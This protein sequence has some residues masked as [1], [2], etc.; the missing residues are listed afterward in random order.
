MLKPSIFSYVYITIS[1]KN[2]QQKYIHKKYYILIIHFNLF[3]SF[4][5]YIIPFNIDLLKCYN[6]NFLFVN[7]KRTFNLP[8][9]QG[10]YLKQGTS[11]TY[12]NESLPNITGVGGI[13]DN[14]GVSLNGAFE[15]AGLSNNFG[16]TGITGRTCT[17][18][19][20]NASRSSSAYQ[21]NAKVNP[22]NAEILY[23]I[24]Y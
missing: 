5:Y 21:N 6:K 20:F 3:N 13:V 10:R 12:G 24:K 4:C 16:L 1:Y 15:S 17:T 22:D 9:F 11:G 18:Q 2:Y 23:Y 19:I 14:T 7:Y 8:N